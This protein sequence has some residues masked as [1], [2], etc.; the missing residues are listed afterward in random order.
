MHSASAGSR[1]V[2]PPLLA[3]VLVVVLVVQVLGL[4]TR[5]A[6]A[7]GPSATTPDPGAAGSLGFNR[8]EYD[9]PSKVRVG[10]GAPSDTTATTILEMRQAGVVYY[11]KSGSGPF[12]VLIFQHGNHATCESGSA[13]DDQLLVGLAL[14]ATYSEGTCSTDDATVDALL[15]IEDSASFR[16]YDYLAEQLATQGYIVASLDINDITDWGNN[17]AESGYLGR[18]QIISKTLDLIGS[19]N[20][21]SGPEGIGDALVGRVGLDQ[22]VGAGT[23]EGSR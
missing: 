1:R 2:V 9:L 10:R 6:G 23:G 5:T 19:W 13:V 7:V 18:A 22:G 14:L 17:A 21:R 8:A 11:P 3:V 15:Q 4:L 20:T 16:G 12:P